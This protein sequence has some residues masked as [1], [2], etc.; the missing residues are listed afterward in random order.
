MLIL[1]KNIETLFSYSHIVEFLGIIVSLLTLYLAFKINRKF[2]WNH[3]RTKQIDHICELIE[4][5]NK[6]KISITFS[7]YSGGGAYSGSGNSVLFNIFEIGRYD[8][9]EQNGLNSEYEEEPV[10]FYHKCNQIFDI[11][12]FIDSPLIPRKI[13]DELLNFHNTKC[14]IL[15]NNEIET[16]SNF[17]ELQTEILDKNSIFNEKVEGSLIQGNAIAFASW[18]NL[19]EYSN[20]IKKVIGTWLIDNGIKDNNIRQDF[21]N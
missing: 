3:L 17:V 6:T 8:I 9:I 1:T 14:F 20:S 4:Y 18:L 21:K 10:L 7:T 12:N 11:S 13:A 16:N 15:R 2:A 19:K 5:L